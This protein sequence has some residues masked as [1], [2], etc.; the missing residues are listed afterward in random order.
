MQPTSAKGGEDALAAARKSPVSSQMLTLR[1]ECAPKRATDDSKSWAP[2]ILGFRFGAI[3]HIDR[4]RTAMDLDR[5]T[6]NGCF[7]P[8]EIA[9]A[10]M[11][12][13]DDVARSAGLGRDAFVRKKRIASQKTQNRLRENRSSV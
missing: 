4:L 7:E 6:E 5:Y 11:T 9:R 8:A 1:S 3:S 2:P 10:F 12:T 13:L